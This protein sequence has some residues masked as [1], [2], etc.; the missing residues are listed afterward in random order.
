[1][2]TRKA[3]RLAWTLWTICVSLTAGSLVL[4]V[5]NSS[6]PD[7]PVFGWWLGNSTVVV[8]ATVGAIVASR[9]PE[10]PVGWMISCFAIS[11]GTSS[12]TAQYAIYALLAQPGTVPAGEVAA[13]VGAWQ[14]PLIIGF[15]ASY[16]LLFPTGHLPGRLWRF[17]AYAIGVFVVV[18]VFLAAFAPDAYLGSL[19]GIR[20]PL[21]IAGFDVVYITFCYTAAPVL[22]V[23]VAA[24]VFA[25]LRRATGVE[26]QQIK[27]FAYAAAILAVGTAF[28]VIGLLVENPAWL[29]RIAVAVFT[30]SGLATPVAIGIA[31]LRHRLYDI[32]RIINQTL[33]YATLTVS[34]VAVYFVAVAGLQRILSPLTG[35]DSQLAVVASTLA[36]AALFNP[37]RHR[38]QSFIDRRFYRSRYD[39]RKTLESFSARLRDETDLETLS[40]D[41]ATVARSTLHP[42]HFSLWLRTSER[43]ERVG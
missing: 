15:Q 4:L 22:F 10:N 2:N 31:I 29:G 33:V 37:L 1:M 16:M 19:D 6:Y 42:A 40:N 3:V 26:R 17:L 28:N 43:E 20:N 23:A 8:D 34:L 30:V 27:W 39:A 25:R 21:G 12:F 5:L 36:I 7:V 35:E 32:D 14:L 11:V 9:R 13:W 38:L 41:L 18:G 24:S